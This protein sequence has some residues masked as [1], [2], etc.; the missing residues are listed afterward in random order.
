VTET[1]FHLAGLDVVVRGAAGLLA[2]LPAPYRRY[3]RPA[4]APGLVVE[5]ALDPSLD[6]RP[7]GA[8]YPAFERRL[9]GS[10]LEVERADAAGTIEVTAA[11]ITAR[12]RVSAHPNSVEACLRVALSVALPRHDTLLFHA[13]AIAARGRAHV[14][15][16]VSGAGKSTISSLLAGVPGCVRLAD[17]LLIASRRDGGWFVEAPPFAGTAG[18]PHGEVVPLA[19][20]NLLAQ[21]RAHR[22]QH[23]E[24]PLA[25]RELMRHVV[26]FAAEASTSEIVLGLASRLVAEVPVFR[27]E[28]AKDPGVA[29]VLDIT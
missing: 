1:C 18:L 29:Q 27:L 7:H 9:A 14:F 21:A 6:D 19:D 28:F 25:L 10:A 12:F 15:A 2:A 23:V 24:A 4:A 26:V 20:V 11:P 22:R 17:D 3:V 16:G 5:L 8:G 13:S